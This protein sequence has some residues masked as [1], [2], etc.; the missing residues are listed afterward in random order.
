M[1]IEA[2]K[3]TAVSTTL[4]GPGTGDIAAARLLPAALLCRRPR[5]TAHVASLFFI[6]NRLTMSRGPPDIDIFC[7]ICG[8]DN[9][10]FLKRVRTV[11]AVCPACESFDC[12]RTFLT[13][14]SCE[15]VHCASSPS[16]QSPPLV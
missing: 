12:P 4:Q 2:V 14:C 10:S 3:N 16:W 8:R 13:R 7:S 15:V 9:S 5:P 1:C 6:I 11:A